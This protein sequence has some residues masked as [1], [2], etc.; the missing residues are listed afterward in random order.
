LNQEELKE[1][2]DRKNRDLREKIAKHRERFAGVPEIV[3]ELR[4]EIDAVD[5]ELVN[6]LRRRVALVGAAN[7]AKRVS[8]LPVH[9]P[10]RE[11][12]ILGRHAPQE[13]PVRSAYAAIIQACRRHA[14]GLFEGEAPVPAGDAGGDAKPPA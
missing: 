13:G 10:G 2:V 14:I 4:A 11:A 9:D 12:S 1:Y 3:H 8:G 7:L 6:L 5:G